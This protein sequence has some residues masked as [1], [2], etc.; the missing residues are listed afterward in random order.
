MSLRFLGRV[1]NPR[2]VALQVGN[3]LQIISRAV[4]VGLT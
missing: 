2:E 1:G 4:V 3:L